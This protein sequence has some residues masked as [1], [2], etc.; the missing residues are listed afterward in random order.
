MK[1]TVVW[2]PS[3]EQHL[4]V[5]WLDSARRAEI[6]KAADT[7][8]KQLRINPELQ[9]EQRNEGDRVLFNPPLGILFE[10]TEE[11]RMVR[12]LAVWEIKKRR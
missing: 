12:V 7:L 8:D 6:T 11:D 5:L 3:A 9:G 4:A 1:Y 10:I 2:T